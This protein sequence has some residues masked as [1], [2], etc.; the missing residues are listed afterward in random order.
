VNDSNLAVTFLGGVFG[1]GLSDGVREVIARFFGGFVWI[2][3]LQGLSPILNMN[4]Y[5]VVLTI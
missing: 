5:G 1:S 3:W 4:P 2:F